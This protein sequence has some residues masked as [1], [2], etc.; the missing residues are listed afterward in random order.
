MME[1]N[2]TDVGGTDTFTNVGTLAETVVFVQTSEE[3]TS[4]STTEPQLRVE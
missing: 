3:S 1:M 4:H 2:D